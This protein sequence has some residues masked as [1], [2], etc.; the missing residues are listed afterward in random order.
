MNAFFLYPGIKNG[1]RFIFDLITLVSRDLIPKLCVPRITKSW[2]PTK[3]CV[4]R[5]TKSWDPTKPNYI[6]LQELTGK[7]GITAEPAY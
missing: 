5:I 4:P 2:D 1:C 6:I 7:Q 3:L